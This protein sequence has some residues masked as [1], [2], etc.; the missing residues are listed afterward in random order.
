MAA[1]KRCPDFARILADTAPDAELREQVAI[2]FGEE[3][4]RQAFRRCRDATLAEDAAQDA[5][6]I[7]FQ[8]L[9]TYRGD[10]PLDHWL[11]RLVVSACSRLRRGRKNDP[12]YNRPLDEASPT[13]PTPADEADPEAEVFLK[14]RISLLQGAWTRSTN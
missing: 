5:L 9:G 10:A 3:L 13:R 7:A 11:K 2:C 8:S 12:N 14:E 1:A 6:V 4:N